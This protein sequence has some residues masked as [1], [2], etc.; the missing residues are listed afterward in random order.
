VETA[1]DA[2]AEDQ[3]HRTSTPRHAR[4]RRKSATADREL[5]L[6]ADIRLSMAAACARHADTES[7]ASGY[8]RADHH[9]ASDGEEESPSSSRR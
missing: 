5:S 3:S 6:E 8:D 9:S 2:E 4:M 7:V 1:E